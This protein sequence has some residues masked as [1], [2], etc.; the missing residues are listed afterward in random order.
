MGR[1][2][3]LVRVSATEGQL[4]RQLYGSEFELARSRPRPF[5]DA[6]SDELVAAKQ[7]L[8]SISRDPLSVTSTSATSRRM[9]SSGDIMKCL[10]PCRR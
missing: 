1:D 7:S 8:R 6:R 10:A 3:V 5:S 4:D 9:Y 2:E